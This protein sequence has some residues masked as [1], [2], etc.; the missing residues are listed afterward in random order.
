MPDQH[1][2]QAP[3]RPH[4]HPGLLI[5]LEG[6]DGGGKT[7]QA[8]R[9]VS[10]LRETGLDVV[11][12]HDPGSTAVGERLRQI[13]LDRASVHLSVRAEVFIYMAS[14]A[15]LVD[16]VIRPSLEAGRVV[17]TDRFLLSSL[18][19]QGHAGGLPLDLVARL[20]RDATDGLLPDLTL[21][22]DVPL[23]AARA[24]VGPGRDRIEDRPDAYRNRVREGFLHVG[25][26]PSAYPARTIVV[27]ANADAD[28]VFGRIQNEVG[29]VLA[30]GPRP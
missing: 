5:A 20:G 15:Q 1:T 14:R 18:V 8:A 27:D 3:F 21:V 6:P 16:E 23:D 12:C 19:Y 13:V 4:P 30:I 22:L 9:L 24:R 26:D 11:A 29:R 17:V 25:R 2:D 28:S 7:T 10:W